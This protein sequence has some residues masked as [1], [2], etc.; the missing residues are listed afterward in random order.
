[1]A[2]I[3]RSHKYSSE[4]IF[5]CSIFFPILTANQI[6]PTS[7][8][9]V[10][11]PSEPSSHRR[12]TTNSIYFADNPLLPS[13]DRFF[14]PNSAYGRT[15][16][17][18]SSSSVT[19]LPNQY[20]A[21]RYLPARN[22]FTSSGS[23]VATAP[24]SRNANRRTPFVGTSSAS[25]VPGEYLRNNRS[26]LAHVNHGRNS[27]LDVAP[28]FI[29]PY[30]PPESA[31]DTHWRKGFKVENCKKSA[32]KRLMRMGFR[33]EEAVQALLETGQNEKHAAQL[34]YANRAHYL[35]F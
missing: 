26:N 29:Q 2:S 23:T 33:E 22:Q 25:S 30:P 8:N 13:D 18:S 34:L 17:S 3:I 10:F 4:L 32:V 11:F 20:H 24:I 9:S 28:P 19:S 7:N 1:M 14:P 5:S 31:L 15:L 27:A 16:S 12:H 35:M 6:Y 21:N